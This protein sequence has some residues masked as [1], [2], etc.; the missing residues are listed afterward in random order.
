M[1]EVLFLSVFSVAMMTLAAVVASGKG[2][3]LIAGYNTASPKDRE[4]VDIRRLRGVIAGILVYTTVV[5]WIPELIGSADEVGAVVLTVVLIFV[6]SLVGI[7][8]ANT[9]C[10]KKGND[11]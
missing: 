11:K 9:W 3:N 1:I 6:G 7:L 4:Q 8:L 2:D 10:I 5:L